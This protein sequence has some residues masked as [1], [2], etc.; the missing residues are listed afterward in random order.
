MYGFFNRLL[1][2]DSTRRSHRV[3]KVDDA[4]LRAYLGGKGIATHYLLGKISQGIDPLGEENLLIFAIGPLTGTSIWGSCRYGVFTKSPLTGYYAESYSGGSAA[5]YMAAT[6]FDMIVIGGAAKD[7]VWIE[8]GDEDVTFHPAEHLWGLD[9]Y[10]TEARVK[11]E[12]TDESAGVVCIGPAG[13][14]G[15]RFAVIENDRWRSAGRTG[16]GAVM[17]SKKIKAIAFRGSRRRQVAQPDRLQSYSRDMVR[18]LKHDPMVLAY[19][20]KGTSMMVDITSAAGAFPTRYW[21]KGRADHQKQIN[22]QALHECLQVT[23]HACRRCFMACGR[24]STVRSGRHQGLKIEGPEYETI[25]VFGGLCEVSSIEEIAY[26]NDLCDRLGLDTITGG[27][28]TAFT[29]EASR[30]GKIRRRIDYGDADR[31][32]DLLADMAYRRDVG[33]LLALGIRETARAWGMED[34]AVHVKGLEPAAFDPRVLKGM[35][36]AYGTSPRG[37]CH[38]RSTFYKPELAGMVDPAAVAGKAEMFAEW[39][40]RLTLFDTLI[41]C[42]FYRD[43]YKWEELSELIHMVC[44]IKVDT[45]QLRS[46]A[47]TIVGM[48]RKFNLAQGLDPVEDRLPQR[49]FR[50]P[51][52]ESGKV[53]TEQEMDQLLQEYYLVRGWDERGVPPA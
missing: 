42:R 27:N 41:L 6:G 5:E 37:A 1:M 48:T 2:I 12:L 15:V 45:G 49:F 31:I 21:Q 23:P 26:L 40:D 11:S 30:Q 4:L 44:G 52:P 50:E 14:I 20:T 46:I 51:L 8:I 18:K 53:L 22:A 16:A 19:K 36:L 28:L 29:I 7:P 39:E 47:S 38:L 34:Q 35:A 25:G 33:D 24:L 13:E 17:G 32:A 3:Q 43:L 10:E 9:T